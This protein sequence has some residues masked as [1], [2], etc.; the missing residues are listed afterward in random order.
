MEN[1]QETQGPFSIPTDAIRDG[2]V[3]LDEE[4]I[5][6]A[7]AAFLQFFHMSCTDLRGT[8]IRQW[9]PEDC[10]QVIQDASFFREKKSFRTVLTQMDGHRLNL[11][12][13]GDYCQLNNH[14]RALLI[15]RDISD[16]VE[17]EA[18]LFQQNQLF[19]S[20]IRTISDPV[21]IIGLGYRVL[22][23][24]EAF[25]NLFQYPP[26]TLLGKPV[27]HIYADEVSFG[28]VSNH[29]AQLEGT[30]AKKPL[31]VDLRTRFGKV[32]RVEAMDALIQ[33]PDGDIQGYVSIFRSVA[34][35]TQPLIEADSA[36]HQTAGPSLVPT[37]VPSETKG[38]EEPIPARMELAIQGENERVDLNDLLL[39]FQSSLRAFLQKQARLV[40]QPEMEL[41]LVS[42][43][44]SQLAD[45]VMALCLTIRNDMPHEGVI[46]IRTHNQNN[47]NEKGNKKVLMV[48]EDATPGRHSPLTKGPDPR[49]T[50][51]GLEQTFAILEKSRARVRTFW[52]E[53]RL[54]AYH[55]SFPGL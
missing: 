13:R 22:F 29:W 39:D 32:I 50:K 23:C 4:Q 7:N 31:L 28:L 15:L 48:I 41:P 51:Q 40:L 53:Q 6:S 12:L 16:F 38:E 11:E 21:L 54:C 36:Y 35:E 52:R 37:A 3:I 46:C 1:V 9:L 25:C 5:L 14:Q 43:Q 20:I 17:T 49:E 26:D 18:T 24:N 47:P 19:E 55:I 42:G 8:E 30:P 45:V 33:S 44:R 34:E 27:S 10:H 2:L